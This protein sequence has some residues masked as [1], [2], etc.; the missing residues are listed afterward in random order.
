M[1]V[2]FDIRV[3]C[4]GMKQEPRAGWVLRQRYCTKTGARRERRTWPSGRRARRKNRYMT[5]GLTA[6]V[7]HAVAEVHDGGAN[8]A[9]AHDG[10][11]LGAGGFNFALGG[12]G[13][14][15]APELAGN[16]GGLLAFMSGLER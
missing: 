3:P 12:A 14:D 5:R 4:R 7:F 16:L 1:M 9:K 6:P 10:G 11:F 8:S 13:A 15:N 2:F